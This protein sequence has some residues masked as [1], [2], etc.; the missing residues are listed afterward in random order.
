M[1]NVRGV[2]LRSLVQIPAR[3]L[4]VEAR[5]H[6]EASTA[7]R[8]ARYPADV[9]ISGPSRGTGGRIVAPRRRE[10]SDPTKRR[11]FWPR[12]EVLEIVEQD[13]RV[14]L[15]DALRRRSRRCLLREQRSLR[16]RRE[17]LGD[18]GG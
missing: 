18:L 15:H 4:A 12:C 11:S 5:A 1:K 10:R 14:R 2:I 8:Q 13:D 17:E 3:D 6:S 9:A 16:V 7:D